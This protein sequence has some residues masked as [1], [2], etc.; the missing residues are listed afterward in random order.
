MLVRRKSV[1]FQNLA[2]PAEYDF[3]KKNALP[4]ELREGKAIFLF[5]AP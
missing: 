1:L 2:M 4:A 3:L 5:I